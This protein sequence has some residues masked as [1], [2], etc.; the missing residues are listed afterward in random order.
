MT[1]AVTILNAVVSRFEPTMSRS[2]FLMS[3]PR[4]MQ[5]FDP[6]VLTIGLPNVVSLWL[7]LNEHAS[8]NSGVLCVA[9]NVS[10]CAFRK[11]SRDE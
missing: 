4:S 9:R 6:M 8:R 5:Q 10:A 11:A 7:S 1:V 2:P 3:R